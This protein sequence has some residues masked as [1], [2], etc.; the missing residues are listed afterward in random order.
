MSPTYDTRQREALEVAKQIVTVQAQEA[1]ADARRAEFAAQ[2]AELEARFFILTGGT[3]VA[4]SAKNG[5]GRNVPDEPAASSSEDSDTSVAQ[6]VVDAFKRYPNKR[7]PL[8]VVVDALTG[9]GA[10]PALIRSAAARRARVDK[11]K[12]YGLRNAGRGKYK[13]V[14]QA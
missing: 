13:Y 11:P 3:P 10:S 12:P 6:R 5:A 1:E 8:Q 4:P 9:P 14:P 2:R 7:I